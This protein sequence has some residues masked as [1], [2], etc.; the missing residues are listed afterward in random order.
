[1]AVKE[2]EEEF[3]KKEKEKEKE[4]GKP[5]THQTLITERGETA[6]GSVAQQQPRI[7]YPHA[8]MA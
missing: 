8:S 2:E 5:Q 4:K 7:V 6:W 3:P 1:M